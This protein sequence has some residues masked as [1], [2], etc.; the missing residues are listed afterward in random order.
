[1]CVTNILMENVIIAER[2][3]ARQHVR[4]HSYIVLL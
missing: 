3:S 2:I 4:A 1:M